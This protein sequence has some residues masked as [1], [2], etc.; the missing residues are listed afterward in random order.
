ML[1]DLQR[2]SDFGYGQKLVHIRG[3][4]LSRTESNRRAKLDV[5]ANICSVR[6]YRFTLVEHDPSEPWLIVIQEHR[7]IELDDD[8]DF[9]AWARKRWPAPRWMVELDPWQLTPRW[10]R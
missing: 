4:Y 8:V 1:V 3:G 10:P 7:S 2:H 9:F 6:E 5:D